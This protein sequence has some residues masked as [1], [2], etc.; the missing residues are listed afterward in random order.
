M[1]PDQAA[2][3]ALRRE[4]KLLRSENAY[5][6]D[7]LLL[8]G[9]PRGLPAGGAVANAPASGMQAV[10]SDGSPPGEIAGG[11]VPG[12][13]GAMLAG[14]SRPPTS[15]ATATAQPSGEELMRRLLDTQRL[16]VAVSRENDRLAGL[17]QRLSDGRQLV[18]D[19]YKARQEALGALEVQGPGGTDNGLKEHCGGLRPIPPACLA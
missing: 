5:L 4:V 2:L 3:S 18:A 7:Q 16:L 15:G 9:Q 1:D 17:N 14:G 12:A 13:A 6:R 19:E 11:V 10:P 8:A